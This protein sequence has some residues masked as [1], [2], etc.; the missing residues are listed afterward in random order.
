MNYD[1]DSGRRQFLTLATAATGAMGA[2]FAAIPFAAS[3]KPSERAKALGAPVQVDISKLEPGAMMTV[4]WR[5]QPIWVVHRTRD[6]L[7]RLPKN[8]SRLKDPKSAN[9][10]QPKYAANE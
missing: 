5:K 8:D 6:M 2:V 4:Q 7:E 3:W 10:E 1:V 9:S